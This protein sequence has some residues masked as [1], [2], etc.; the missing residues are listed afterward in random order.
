MDNEKLLRTNPGMAIIYK[1]LDRKDAD[2]K[3][4][5]RKQSLEFLESK[6]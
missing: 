5:I 6:P 1:N 4:T 2:S 3:N